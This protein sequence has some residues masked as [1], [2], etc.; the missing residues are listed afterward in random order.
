MQNDRYQFR[1]ADVAAFDPLTLTAGTLMV[2]GGGLSAAG[3]LAGGNFAKFAGQ[4]QQQEA[5]YRAKQLRMNAGQ[6]LAASQRQMW[7][8]QNKTNLAISTS[9]ANAAANGVNVGAGSSV[10]NIGDLAKR[11][12]YIASMDLFNGKSHASALLNEAKGAEFSGQVSAIEGEEKQ[13]ASYLAAGGEALGS[14]GSALKLG[15]RP[16]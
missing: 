2:A 5:N 4:A 13:Q 7:E 16:S 3:T 9:R 12:E 8:S 14:A 1:L 15:L 6:A 10:T 11:G